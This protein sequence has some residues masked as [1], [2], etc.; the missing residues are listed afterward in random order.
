MNKYI[1]IM[2]MFIVSH[3]KADAVFTGNASQGENSLYY[4]DW[5]LTVGDQ[6]DTPGEWVGFARQYG[7]EDDWY[8]SNDGNT[9][10]VGRARKSVRYVPQNINSEIYIPGP[11][12][13]EEEAI[14]Y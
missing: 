4:N 2:L 9:Y 14:Y 13:V 12:I 10:R 11:E 6:L 3:I 7:L 8:S 5:D 1:L